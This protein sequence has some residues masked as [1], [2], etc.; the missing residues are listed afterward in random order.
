MK[1][2]AKVLMMNGQV[3]LMIFY[4]VRAIDTIK[5]LSGLLMTM[6]EL[7]GMILERCC[8]T[9]MYNTILPMT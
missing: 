4:K 3:T 2:Q 6:A 5:R 9:L 1:P 7:S 8:L